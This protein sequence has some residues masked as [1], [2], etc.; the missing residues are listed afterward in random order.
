MITGVIIHHYIHIHTSHN[1]TYK[2]VLKRK[3]LLIHYDYYCKL[4]L[5]KI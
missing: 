1:Y 5:V 3:Y 2:Y 4:L